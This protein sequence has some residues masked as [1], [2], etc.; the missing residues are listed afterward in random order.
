MS[1]PSVITE[2][3]ILDAARGVFLERGISATTAEVARRAGIAEGSIFKRFKTKIELFRA[4]MQPA[5]DDPSWLNLLAAQAGTDLRQGLVTVGLE[6]IE[7]FRQVM[8]LHI[9]AWSNPTGDL[10]E[11]PVNAPA[12]RALKR[13]T[14]FFDAEMRA[15]RLRRHDP[16]ILART[17]MGSLH[18]YVF[19]EMVYKAHDELPLPAESFLR[20]L[21][22]LLYTGVERK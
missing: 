4:A 18:N 16:E 15:G 10:T 17:Y 3:Q 7:F 21:V 11:S 8:P 20:G 6:A 22:N 9:M 1:R 12:L 14:A 19:Y 2:V 13:V 5:M